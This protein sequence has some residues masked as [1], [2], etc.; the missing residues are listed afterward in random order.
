MDVV[1]PVVVVVPA[2]VVVPVVVVIEVEV[3]SSSTE[4]TS[5]IYESFFSLPLLSWLLT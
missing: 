1:V 5:K 4:N 2:V 3:V